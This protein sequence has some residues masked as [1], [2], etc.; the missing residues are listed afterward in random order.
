MAQ[1]EIKQYQWLGLT[2]QPVIAAYMVLIL[3]YFCLFDPYSDLV[4]AYY[5]PH[6]APRGACPERK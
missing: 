4:F 3:A 6:S 1:A 2:S 5:G